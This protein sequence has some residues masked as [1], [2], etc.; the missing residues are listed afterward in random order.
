LQ[1]AHQF[2]RNVLVISL[3]AGLWAFG[4]RMKGPFFPLYV[5]ALGGSYLHIGII[6]SIGSLFLIVAS[7]LGGYLAD[8]IG[9]RKII[10]GMSFL[11]SLNTL[12]YLISPS[13]EYLILASAFNSLFV[14]LRAPAMSAII[15]DSTSVRTRTK[16]FAA[17]Q[18]LRIL[19]GSASPIIVGFFMESFGVISAQ[20]LA[21]A[22]AFVTSMTSTV[23]RFLF[24]EETLEKPSEAKKDLKGI[25]KETV[26]GFRQ[27]INM[28]P[29]QAWIIICTSILFTVGA[30]L[31]ADF[32]VTYAV[33]DVI[34]LSKSEWGLVFGVMSIVNVISMTL[35]A[36]A[37]DRFGRLKLIV[38]AM[39][40]TPLCVLGFV[41]CRNFLQVLVVVSAIA[42]LGGMMESP[43]KALLFDHSPSE[44]RGRIHALS[45]MI[46][47]LPGN[48]IMAQGPTRGILNGISNM[49]GGLSYGH[50]KAL[51]FYMEAVVVGSSAFVGLFFIK[52]AKKR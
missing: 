10:Y 22:C 51:P 47:S 9:R 42:V 29:R 52:E 46:S 4:G 33:E 36:S 15:A 49:I 31:G 50:S 26:S 12:L 1:K 14:G 39:F 11:V 19:A 30:S 48:T 41:Y 45:N 13:W 18:V 5:L 25:L 43:Y 28:M 38:P 2:N 27:T 40:M 44:H 34:G 6:A 3:T 35:S 20:R 32:F 8:T 23:L 17:N 21:Y 7:F 16:G 24:L 37:S